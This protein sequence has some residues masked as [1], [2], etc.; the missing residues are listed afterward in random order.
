MQ[1]NLIE[2]MKKFHQQEIYNLEQK[3][4]MRLNQALK[5]SCENENRKTETREDYNSRYQ[6]IPSV[7]GFNNSHIRTTLQEQQNL[8]K[9]RLKKYKISPL[10]L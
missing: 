8:M 2:N 9:N 7:S 3:W 5:T 6:N 1:E 10:Q 4:K